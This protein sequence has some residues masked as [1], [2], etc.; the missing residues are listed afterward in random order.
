MLVPF[1]DIVA[2]QESTHLH[3]KISSPSSKKH[4]FF[5]ER[6]RERERY[7]AY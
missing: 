2:L 3:I 4:A 1:N 5:K 6:E 7:Q